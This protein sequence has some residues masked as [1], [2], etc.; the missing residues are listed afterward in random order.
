MARGERSL[1][2]PSGRGKAL[3]AGF[4]TWGVW[5]GSR[6]TLS[7]LKENAEARGRRGRVLLPSW[8]PA[9]QEPKGP[10]QPS[11]ARQGSQ[12]GTTKG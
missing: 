8:D 7:L 2:A 5:P 9:A 12:R 6:Q 4:L 3:G 11:E 10:G 1:G